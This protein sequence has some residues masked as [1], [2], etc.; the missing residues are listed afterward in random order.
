MKLHPY[1]VAEDDL[2]MCRAV[3]KAVGDGFTLMIDTL[4]YPGPYGRRDALRAGRVLDELDFGWF[5]HPLPK[6]DLGGLA[7]LTRSCQVVRVRMA[8]R[9]EDM[10]EY[11]EMVRRRCMDIMAGSAAFG[12]TDLM[13][14]A[15]VAD[16]NHMNVEPHNSGGGTASLHVLLAITNADYHEVAVPVGCSDETIYPGVYLDTAKVDSEGY[17]NTPTKPGLGFEIDFA[18]ARKVTAETIKA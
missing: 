16:V 11:D 6:T 15:H 17:V 5:E 3:R 13:K 18:E 4:A 7:D 14:L 8:D 1:C 9:V 10:H 12:I 2:R